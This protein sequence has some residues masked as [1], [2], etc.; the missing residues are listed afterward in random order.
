VY[1]GREAVFRQGRDQP[2]QGPPARVNG[3]TGATAYLYPTGS[4]GGEPPTDGGGSGRGD[5]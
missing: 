1:L 3:K 4:Y 5:G 2:G